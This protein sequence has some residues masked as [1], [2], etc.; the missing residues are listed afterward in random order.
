MDH[1]ENRFTVLKSF[2][3][4][5]IITVLIVIVFNFFDIL[6]FKFSRE[7]SGVFFWF[8][9]NVVNSVANILNPLNVGICLILFFILTISL[10][11]IIKE[12]NKKK[13]ILDKIKCLESELKESVT[14]YKLIVSHSILSIIATGAV[15]HIF[16]YVLGVSRPKYYFLYGYERIDNFNLEHKV[17]ALPSGHTQAS[18]TLAILFYIYCNRYAFII[19]FIASMI[20]LSRI[21]MSMHFPSDLIFGAY[22]GSVFPI[23]L[24]NYIYKKKFQKIDMRKIIKFK[25]YCRFI[26]YKI[27]V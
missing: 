8:F 21:F 24:Y 10:C 16:K 20:A 23:I 17:N 2:N 3:F 13:L 25:T 9:E 19:F 18:F 1:I 12:P 15:C 7:L 26:C 6:I 14:F 11:N 27:Y 22:L 4:F 5:I